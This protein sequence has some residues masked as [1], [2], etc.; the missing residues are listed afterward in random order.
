MSI[1]EKKSY[2]TFSVDNSRLIKFS[3][4]QDKVIV[5]IYNNEPGI[6]VGDLIVNL[7]IT[8]EIAYQLAPIFQ[9]LAKKAGYKDPTQSY[10]D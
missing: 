1:I 5:D 3:A 2:S 9:E 4:T 6:Y 7:D 8:P 10:L